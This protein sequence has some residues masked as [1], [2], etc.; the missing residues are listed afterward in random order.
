MIYLVKKRMN[1]QCK[2][3][4]V[5]FAKTKTLFAIK[6]ENWVQERDKSLPQI[7]ECFYIHHYTDISIYIF[8]ETQLRN[9]IGVV[10]LHRVSHRGGGNLDPPLTTKKKKF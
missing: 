5:P 10:L 2:N 7:G 9:S 3:N 6:G 4:T 1:S 8:K